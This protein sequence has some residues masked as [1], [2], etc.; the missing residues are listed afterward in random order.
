M[1]LI[2]A[3]CSKKLPQ[4]YNAGEIETMAVAIALSFTQEIGIKRT[5]LEEDSL[6]VIKALDKDVRSLAPIG[7]LVED[8]KV[9][10]QNFDQL[11]YSHT[12]REG[13]CVAH[14]LTRYAIDISNFLVWME[15]VPPHLQS[16]LQADLVC[17]H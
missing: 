12:K 7:L 3:S 1:K 6:V 16:V 13:N 5:I 4:A 14:S 8:V 15:D 9:L 2:L 11:L 17:L 10:S